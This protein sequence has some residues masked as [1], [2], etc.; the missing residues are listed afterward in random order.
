M[1]GGVSSTLGNAISSAGFIYEMMDVR[2][3]LWKLTPPA[4]SRR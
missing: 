2:G 3:D 4:K 1:P